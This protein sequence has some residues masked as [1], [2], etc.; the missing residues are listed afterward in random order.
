[1]SVETVSYKDPLVEGVSR[2]FW[3]ELQRKM[4]GLVKPAMVYLVHPHFPTGVKEPH[5]AERL[6]EVLEVNEVKTLIVVDQ[7]YLGFTVLEPEAAL[8]PKPFQE[9]TED[10][11]LLETLAQAIEITLK[12]RRFHIYIYF[13]YIYLSLKLLFNYT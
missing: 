4:S 1:M 7:T 13:T 9:P 6:R 2:G 3:E 8:S 10:D 5:F 12:E 11:E